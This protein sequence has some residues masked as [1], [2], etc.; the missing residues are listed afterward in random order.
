MPFPEIHPSFP[1]TTII[2]DWN[3]TLLNDLAH[4]VTTINILLKERHLSLLSDSRYREVFSFPV[5]EYYEKVGFDF[6]KEDFSVPARQF[7]ERYNA[8]IQECSLHNHVRKVLK[9]FHEKKIRQFVLSAMKQDMLE[10]TLRFHGILPVFEKVAGL[11]NHYAV[12]KVERGRELLDS[13]QINPEKTC[14]IGDTLHDSEVARELGIS[15]ML[16]ADG[17]Q[18]KKRLETSGVNVLNSLADLL[19]LFM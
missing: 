5:R 6:S 10:E 12:S 11:D 18:S 17:H 13:S 3:G 2:W 7:I 15:C 4:C 16:I 1:Y 8:G 14:M 9:A 19:P